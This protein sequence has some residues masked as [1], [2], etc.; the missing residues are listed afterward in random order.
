MRTFIAFVALLTLVLTVP[1]AYAHAH[2]DH[3]SPPVGGSVQSAPHELTITF[4]QDL[5]PVFSTIE[6]TGPKG[7]R[8]DQGKPQI[9][10]NTMRIEIK[11]AGQGTYHVRWQALSVDTHKTQGTY[12]FQV[13]GP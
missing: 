6:V 1:R 2:L 9:S 7:E 11:D 4:T 13:G 10:G 8:L 5:E 3:A 12:S